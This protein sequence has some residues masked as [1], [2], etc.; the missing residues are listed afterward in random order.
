M[1]SIRA[2]F[3]VSTASVSALRSTCPPPSP[4]DPSIS[5]IVLSIVGLAPSH[6]FE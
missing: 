5:I 6:F 1:F 3:P 4:R 2:A